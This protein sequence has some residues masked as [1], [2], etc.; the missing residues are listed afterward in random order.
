MCKMHVSVRKTAP[1]TLIHLLFYRY[2]AVRPC[3]SGTVAANGPFTIRQMIY[4]WLWSI[5]RMVLTQR[6]V[7]TRRKSCPT[8]TL[9]TT[10]PTWTALVAIP[11]LR[12]EKPST[13]VRH[14]T[15]WSVC[16]LLIKYCCHV[17]TCVVRWDVHEAFVLVKS[18]FHE[19]R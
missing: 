4:G 13:A 16:L 9:Y 15:A 17:M 11:G 1:A 10:N 8:A 3:L 5:D 7:C 19:P 12:Y 6:N 2:Y 18:T 14:G